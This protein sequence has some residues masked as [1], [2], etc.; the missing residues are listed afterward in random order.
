VPLAETRQ[1]L[2]LGEIAGTHH[3]KRPAQLRR[4]GVRAAARCGRDRD[5]ALSRR[6]VVEA[7]RAR[8]GQHHELEVR[9][10]LDQRPRERRA[11]AQQAEDLERR[12]LLRRVIDRLEGFLE[13]RDLDAAL[14]Q[15]VPIRHAHGDLLVI[16]E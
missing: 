1:P 11:L 4:R 13:H 6:L 9:Q 5:A 10:L 8:A 15:A 3:E 14:L 16:V 2:G 7:R 12:Q